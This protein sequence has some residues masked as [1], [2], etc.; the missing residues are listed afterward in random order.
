MSRV[1]W[2]QHRCSLTAD[3]RASREEC[4]AQR[5]NS[6][7]RLG[8]HAKRDPL[9]ELELQKCEPRCPFNFESRQ[10]TCWTGIVPLFSRASCLVDRHTMLMRGAPCP[11]S[12]VPSVSGWMPSP[13]RS[14]YVPPRR[15]RLVSHAM[16]WP[17]TRGDVRGV[18]RVDCGGHGAAS[19]RTTSAERVRANT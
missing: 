3:P 17:A 15:D 4:A 19:P 1:L 14:S 11:H 5:R 16:R 7:A 13:L 9:R 12:Q 10:S 18:G 8:A 2:C 6:S